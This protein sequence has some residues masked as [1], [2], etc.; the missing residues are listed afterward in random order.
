MKRALTVTD[1][2]RMW[3]MNIKSNTVSSI[4]GKLCL[5]H[6]WAIVIASMKASVTGEKFWIFF[7]RIAD[8]LIRTGEQ[9]CQW[10]QY[11]S[12][13]LIAN[14]QNTSRRR[15]RFNSAVF[16]SQQDIYHHHWSQ[17]LPHFHRFSEL[18]KI[19]NAQCLRKRRVLKI[20]LYS[21]CCLKVNRKRRIPIITGIRV[22]MRTSTTL[23]IVSI[24]PMMC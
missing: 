24:P 16:R 12:K 3:L 2:N 8:F 10:R 14:Y 6:L 18:A 11:H 9:V 15:I 1:I 4:I 5:N 13:D 20:N 7:R 23:I 21:Q 17:Q 22:I 19:L